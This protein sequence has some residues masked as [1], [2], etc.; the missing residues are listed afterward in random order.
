MVDKS[1]L[2]ADLLTKDDICT[3]VFCLKFLFVKK[4]SENFEYL[5]LRSIYN[6]TY[7]FF[8]CV[9]WKKKKLFLVKHLGAVFVLFLVFSELPLHHCNL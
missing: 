9:F 1:C 6:Y 4:S 2:G 5:F 8:L 7:D 3:H